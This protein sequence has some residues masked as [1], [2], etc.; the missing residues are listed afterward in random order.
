ML[1]LNF[2]KKVLNAEKIDLRPDSP[3]DVKNVV[4]GATRK[5]HPKEESKIELDVYADEDVLDYTDK[6]KKDLLE[7]KE[8]KVIKMVRVLQSVFYLLKYSREDICEE[9]TCELNWKKAKN[10]LNDEFFKKIKEYN[11]IGP[12]EDEYHPYQKLNFIQRNIDEIKLDEVDSYSLALGQVLQYLTLAVEIR[13]DDVLRRYQNKQKLK[14]EREQAREQED[15]RIIERQQF[16][17]EEK[18]KWEE[19][20]KKQEKKEGEG[21]GE[22]DQQE[23]EGEGA[24]EKQ[25]DEVATLDK[26][27]LDKPPI[28]IPAEVIDDIDND[29]ELSEEDIN[30]PQE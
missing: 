21:E 6:W 1:K 16:L 24:E 8:Y 27:D 22:G 25:F 11:P 20:H 13:K 3:P 18:V 4:K 26:F 10:Y 7:L 23:A 19:E 30:P 17:E 29:L 9:N 2:R 14:E 12:K 5:H 28:E 15:E